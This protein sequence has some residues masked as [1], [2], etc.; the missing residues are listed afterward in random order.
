MVKLDCRCME[1]FW[2]PYLY[3]NVTNGQTV[4]ITA[5]S[6]ADMCY[7]FIKF[8]DDGISK[9]APGQFYWFYCL[10]RTSFN[11]IW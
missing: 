11:D 6:R 2:T 4:P 8:N 5:R 7:K 3:H 10:F 1:I 9:T